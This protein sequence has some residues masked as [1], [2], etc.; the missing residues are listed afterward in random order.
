MTDN[1]IRVISGVPIKDYPLSPPDI[2][3][4]VLMDCQECNEKMWFSNKKQI[5]EQKY[6]GQNLQYKILCWNCIKDLAN[7]INPSEII[8]KD[9]S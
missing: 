7:K 4:P 6:I 8:L 1:A 3:N 5:E 2:L 9:I